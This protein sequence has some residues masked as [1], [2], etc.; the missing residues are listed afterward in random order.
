MNTGYE[1]TH[2][3]TQTTTAAIITGRGVIR[4]IVINK[5]LAG[6]VITIYDNTAASGNVIGIITCDVTLSD[7][8][9]SID[10]DVVVGTGLTIKTAGANQDITVVYS[11]N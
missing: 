3:T 8:P 11:K 5:P 6:G 4:K 10:Y 9:V 2:I 1:Y 7:S